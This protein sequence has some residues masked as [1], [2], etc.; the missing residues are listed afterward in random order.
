[1]GWLYCFIGMMRTWVK[2]FLF[3]LTP[4]YAEAHRRV[5]HFLSIIL[6][7]FHVSIAGAQ[8]PLLRSI[9]LHG[10]HSIS[11]RE[12]LSWMGLQ[13]QAAFKVEQYQHDLKTIATRY[14]RA[15]FY[16]AVIDPQLQYTPDSSSVSLILNLTEG[17]RVAIGSIDLSG[18]KLVPT[19]EI[20]EKF[21]TRVG[22]VLDERILEQDFEHILTLYEARGY[23]FAKVTVAN[24]ELVEVGQSLKIM[25]QVDEGPIVRISDV[26]VE[27]N[28][29]TKK[30]VIIRE[31]RI[32]LGE[33]YNHEKV[34]AVR[35]LLMRLK[36]FRSVGEPELY[37]QGDK[38]GLLIKV[39]EGNA[40]TFD[41]I[42]GY[43]PPTTI[44]GSDQDGF[45]MGLV[46]VSM[47]NLFGTARKLHVHW[48]REDRSTQELGIRYV[49]PWAF[50]LPVNVGLGFGQRQQDSAYVKRRL[51]FNASMLVFGN[52][53]VGATFNRESVIP[54]SDRVTL[55]PVLKSNT[56]S[57]GVN[58]EYDTR[59]DVISP[60]RGLYYSTDYR[61][62]TKKLTPSTNSAE[63]V[64][65]DIT[66][67]NVSVDVE[68]YFP[69][70]VRQVLALSLHVR[71]LRGSPVDESDLFRLGG[72]N[73]LR[74]YR[75]NQF[76]GSRLVWS[77]VEYRFLVGRRSF[78]YGFFDG[79]Y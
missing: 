7:A 61:V 12:I 27:G 41:G 65:D 5:K 22:A 8:P 30:S 71:E 20:L 77:N 72:T 34:N 23:P 75:E 76:L 32:N 37:I 11:T 6:L 26:R 36:V 73:S 60:R 78:F 10:N 16:F 14:Q 39:Q 31:S 48:R 53:N 54:S 4:S 18:N 21:E 2:G 38:A 13:A 35:P 70:F 58:L 51:E 68:S 63:S 25:I 1:M 46:T 55:S 3:L 62:G 52:L 29:T 59:D 57:V 40:N 67:Q 9:D 69:T 49:E 74:G 42:L 45:L 66:V 28:S 33:P 15:G 43:V 19:E 79:G 24:I 17:P 56:T 64:E 44:G 47:R 50:N